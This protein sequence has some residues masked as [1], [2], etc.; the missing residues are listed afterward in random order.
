MRQLVFID[1]DQTELDAFRQIVGAHYDYITVHW[2]NESAKLFSM[3]AP[4]I[5]VSDLYLPPPTGDSVP[6]NEQRNEAAE[7]ARKVADRFSRLYSVPLGDK[8]RLQ[9][10]NKSHNRCDCNAESAMG[11]DG[12]VSRSRRCPACESAIPAS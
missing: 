4:D 10:T 1:D 3:S 5:F 12:T 9:E 11:C 8:A 7:H 2:P 6:T